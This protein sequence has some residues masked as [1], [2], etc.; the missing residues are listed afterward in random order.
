[1]AVALDI[2]QQDAS[3]QLEELEVV[4][5][6]NEWQ[7]K[8]GVP[9]I[10]GFYIEDLKTVEL[11]PWPRK[12]GKG[13]FIN[14]EGTGGVNDM[15]VVEIAPGGKSEPEKHLYEEMVYVLSGHGSTSVW[16]DENKKLSFEWG[17]G[18]VFAIPLNANYQHFNGSGHQPARYAAVTNAPTIIRLFH[19][20]DFL[21]NNPY[22][23]RDRFSGEDRYFSGDGR[24]LKRKN[25]RVW[26]ANFVPDVHSLH[27]PYLPERGGGGSNV[28]IHMAE[29]SMGA[30]ISQFQVGMYKKGHRHGPGAHVII[31]E[32]QG[33]S[34]LWQEGGEANRKRCDWR[35]GTVVVPP[36]QW[37]H[38]HFNTGAQ[39][40][41]YLALRM[42]GMRFRQAINSE[43]GEGS[44]VSLKLGGW[45]IEYEDEDPEIH[46]MF[47]ADLKAHGAVC[48]M[49]GMVAGC[50][51]IEGTVEEGGDD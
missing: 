10:T 40:A 19:S 28:H 22:Q 25:R 20:S 18:S 7:A 23:F 26:D 50:T 48:R 46:K 11:A 43:R 5:A 16:Y 13:T 35:P 38:Q 45:Q 27:L 4:D 32:G 8:E 21:F 2:R 6:Y 33:F 30:H 42:G 44:A 1:M 9:S 29:N 14:L 49:K 3:G 31:L 36:D 37:F 39:P 24:L 15:Q 47:E 34:L 12:G 17:P 51:G 41:R